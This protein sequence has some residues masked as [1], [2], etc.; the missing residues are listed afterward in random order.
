MLRLT[1][2]LLVALLAFSIEVKVKAAESALLEQPPGCL[3]SAAPCALYNHQSSAFQLPKAPMVVLGKEAV[4]VRKSKADFQLLQGLLWVSEANTTMGSQWGIIKGI[5]STSVLL[6]AKKTGLEIDVLE[7][8]ISIQLRGHN[9][10]LQVP[11]GYALS[12]NAIDTQGWNQVSIPQPLDLAQVIQQWGSL[13]PG[14]K[15][16]MRRRLT[17]VRDH[18]RHAVDESS[19]WQL[20]EVTRELAAVNSE[21]QRQAKRQ[22]HWQKQTDQLLKLF[23]HRLGL[24][25]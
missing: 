19:Q 20:A 8:Q 13:F 11:A 22:R 25:L 18:W 5:G 4:V 10:K 12:V 3:Q 24:G 15:N 9:E 23:R 14:T 16:E 2:R 7:G 17:R 1:L 21:R 6:N